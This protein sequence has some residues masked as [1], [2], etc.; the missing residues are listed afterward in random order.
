MCSPPSANEIDDEAVEEY[1]DILHDHIQFLEEE[2]QRSER[3]VMKLHREHAEGGQGEDLLVA[4]IR[5]HATEG[6]TKPNGDF[7]TTVANIARYV[8]FLRSEFNVDET[9]LKT[10]HDT[11]NDDLS[12]RIEDESDRKHM[13]VVLWLI[14]LKHEARAR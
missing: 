14:L 11:L 1:I 7:T 2:L 9:K 13:S 12:D 8:H 10:F 6:E 5:Q 3:T 4:L